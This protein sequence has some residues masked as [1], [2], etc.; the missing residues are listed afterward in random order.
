MSRRASCFAQHHAATLM[1]VVVSQFTIAVIWIAVGG[2]GVLNPLGVVMVRLVDPTVSGWKLA[3]TEFTSGVK[4]TEL[5]IVPTVVFELPSVTVTGVAPVRSSCTPALARVVGFS[6]A[7]ASVKV[8]FA[9]K[10][11][12]GKLP[13]CHSTPEGKSVTVMVPVV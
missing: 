2:V 3:V 12:V 1:R 11:V 6:C 8:V 7:S 13:F 10:V 4:V 9:E 5:G